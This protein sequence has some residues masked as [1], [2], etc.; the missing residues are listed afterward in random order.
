VP[1][2]ATRLRAKSLLRPAFL[3]VAAI[4]VVLAVRHQGPVLQASFARFGV[5]ALLL[6]QA[7]VM[8]GLL[9]SA[10]CW[11]AVLAALGEPLALRPALHVFF[12]GQIGKYLPGNVFALAAQAELA[13]DHRVPRSRV[14]AAGLVFLGVLTTSGL[15]IAAVTLPFTSP[16]ALR[17]YAWVLPVLP[18]G[19]L[20]LVPAVLHRCLGFALRVTRRP[21]LEAPPS[22]RHLA[23][24]LAWALLMWIAYGG[25]V[26]PLVHAQHAGGLA[27]LAVLGTGGYALA[28]TAGFLF[29]VAPAGAVV[30]E[31]VLV[32]VLAAV[33]TRPE[34]TAVALAS[35]LVQTV[36]DLAWALLAGTA[37]RRR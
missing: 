23:A 37:L 31:A 1:E 36:G 18:L 7:A 3:L 30:R 17:T 10:L 22:S 8:V 5:V 24:A 32:L 13:H 33:M 16:S 28:W 11:R 21:L 6:S 14:V 12:V 34:G 19:L 20:L 26:L 35:R 2:T 27:T 15:L 9:A 4:A 25:H 29:V